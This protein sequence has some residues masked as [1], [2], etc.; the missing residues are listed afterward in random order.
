MASP[1]NA[2]AGATAS[3][4]GFPLD[5]QA[6]WGVVTGDPNPTEDDIAQVMAYFDDSVAPVTQQLARS[7]GVFDAWHCDVPSDT[8]VNRSFF[9]AGSSTGLV[10]EPPITPWPIEN[11]AT[12]I[13]ERFNQA[14]IS[15]KS[16]F[17]PWQIVPLTLL[18]NFRS[19]WDQVDRFHHF[20][21]FLDD[22]EG[23]HAAAVQ[24]HRTPAAH[25][26]SDRS[27]RVRHAPHVLQGVRPVRRV[28]RPQ[29]RHPDAPD[30][31]RGPHLTCAG[32]DAADDGVRR[33][34]RHARPR[35]S[36]SGDATGR[37]PGQDLR[38]RLRPTR[39]AGP[40]DRDLRVTSPRERSS[41]TR[42]RTRRSSARWRPSGTWIR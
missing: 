27:P 25:H 22:A 37:H 41:A 32:Q 7:F 2:P 4:E 6:N 23:G 12:T 8:F 28:G 3:M 38:I 14:G 13:F 31:R 11:T 39:C 35:R 15:W 40:R 9:H 10:T 30:L 1:W 42:C 26:R 24:L 19:L 29:R 21:S 17:D 18:I 34:R 16:Y 36:A 20:S 33:A 5:Y